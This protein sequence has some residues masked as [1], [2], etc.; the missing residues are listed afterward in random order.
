M[1]VSQSYCQLETTDVHQGC[2]Q[3]SALEG[4]PMLNFLLKTLKPTMNQVY[5]QKW[6]VFNPIQRQ[7]WTLTVDRSITKLMF[8]TSWS[9]FVFLLAITS[10][11]SSSKFQGVLFSG[12]SVLNL[13]PLQHIPDND[14]DAYIGDE[15][16]LFLSWHI[17]W[18]NINSVFCTIN[19]AWC[20]PFMQWDHQ[21]NLFHKN[22][23]QFIMNN[24]SDDS[25]YE[26]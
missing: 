15:V 2:W 26:E 9:V 24:A 20:I 6:E 1:A 12:T 14:F 16:R 17:Y 23:I 11:L 25:L 3:K 19:I 5:M 8:L 21:L 22:V 10:I 18:V 7:W 13:R 4:E